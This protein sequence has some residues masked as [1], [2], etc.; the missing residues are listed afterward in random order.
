MLT[1]D[2][3][4]QLPETLYEQFRKQAEQRNHSIEQE[5]LAVVKQAAPTE[6]DSGL[7]PDLKQ[8]LRDL[9]V[10]DDKA[11]WRAAR[12]MFPTR[13]SRQSENLH[14]KRDLEGLTTE[15]EATLRRLKHRRN[16]VMLLRG[17]AAVLLKERGHDITELGPTK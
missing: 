7:P 12:V 10:L 1:K 4:L 3:T 16:E 15:E 13:L 11:L 9:E 6:T 17:R 2:V 8:M 5:L 14:R